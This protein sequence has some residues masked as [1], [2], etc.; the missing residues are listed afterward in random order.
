M[1]RLVRAAAEDAG[2]H[3]A[4]VAS[5]ASFRDVAG[6]LG[7]R[8]RRSDLQAA[9]PGAKSAIVVALSYLYPRSEIRD[10]GSPRGLVARFARGTD[11]HSVLQSRL[12][13]LAGGLCDVLGEFRF[14]VC[15]DTGPISD[16]AVAYAAGLGSFGRNTCLITPG[17]GSW[18]VLGELVTDVELE[19]N[20]PREPE[21][22]G[23]CCLCVEA[24]P[25]GALRGDFTL[26]RS[27]CL[28]DATQ[29]RAAPPPD[30][31]EHWGNRIYGCDV[32]Q[33]VCPLNAGARLTDVPEFS[34]DNA[35]GAEP[36]LAML[37]EMTEEDFDRL[38]A[39][40]A[41]R[42]L[43]RGLIARN[44]GLAMSSFSDL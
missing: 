15:V 13:T 44:A 39:G 28:S 1:A 29:R 20:E 30:L 12:Q 25:T 17:Y 4:G 42:R 3:A 2:F 6:R 8:G 5:V 14:R 38:F 31:T 27:R 35:L 37:A 32:C 34:T 23:S 26:D 24:C 41:M 9:L 11:Y 16:R 19:P 36:E 22:C 40:T 21:V 7:L 43:G 33:E 18:V 10:P